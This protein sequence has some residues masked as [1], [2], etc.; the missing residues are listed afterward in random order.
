MEE[1]GYFPRI[2]VHGKDLTELVRIDSNS[3]RTISLTLQDFQP[4]SRP[5]VYKGRHGGIEVIVKPYEKIREKDA[6]KI[7]FDSPLSMIL[8]YNDCH[9]VEYVSRAERVEVSYAKGFT[10]AKELGRV[11]G[12]ILG[13]LHLRGI[14]YGNTFG[15]HI[16]VQ[17]SGKNN[18]V[19]LT[20]YGASA[21]MP[22]EFLTDIV[23][24]LE[25]LRD[26][27]KSHEDLKQAIEG[28]KDVYSISNDMILFQKA[29]QRHLKFADVNDPL[30]QTLS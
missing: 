21:I 24:A 11:V 2:G 14:S 10:T 27:T 15:K 17:G 16:Y 1:L 3:K 4:T 28:I 26:V 8:D 23:T 7:M 29:V 12:T 6:I 22:S 18:I 25:F 30:R 5:Y 19:K 13:D 20:D 9:Y